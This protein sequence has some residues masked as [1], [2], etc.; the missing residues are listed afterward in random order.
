MEIE[1]EL[2][3]FQRTPDTWDLL[4]MQR[5]EKGRQLKQK[6]ADFMKAKDFRRACWVYRSVQDMMGYVD[7]WP[8][9]L[10]SAGEEL[11]QTSRSNEV[12][13]WLKL[14]QF[15]DVVDLCTEILNGGGISSPDPGNVKALFRRG[16]AY[17]SL[18]EPE[19]AKR[20]FLSV[21]EHDP[22]NAEAK[23]QLARARSSEKDQAK[24]SQ[25]LMRGMISEAGKLD[26]PVGYTTAEGDR[27]R[28]RDAM[29]DKVDQ[30]KAQMPLTL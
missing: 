23:Q 10:R 13:A 22:Q 16:V 27:E 20:D 15:R 6:G 24:K 29:L 3:D 21:L 12:M 18:G 30:I 1:V 7:D 5:V 4:P 17:V 2:T 26:Y 8:E 19:K 14:E 25:S 11:R 9:E 28:Q